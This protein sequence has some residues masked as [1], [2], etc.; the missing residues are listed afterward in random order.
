[1]LDWG[2]R[3]DLTV[4]VIFQRRF[5]A[6]QASV[7]AWI[8]GLKGSELE[9]AQKLWERYATQLVELA[10]RKLGQA[11]RGIADEEDIAQSV[12]QSVWRGAAAGRLENVK[13]RDDLW[14]LLLAITKQKVVDHIRRETSLKRGSGRVHSETATAVQTQAGQKF[15]LDQLVSELPTPEFIAILNEQ[16]FRLLGNLR[17]DQLRQI[18]IA[19]LEGYSVGEI[20]SQL[21]VSTR[22][23]ERKLHLIRAKWSR[24]FAGVV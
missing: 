12:F 2:E 18:A 6:L 22:S 16:N 13:S 21:A 4:L 5:S 14:W 10:R 8:A 20:A 23:I 1:M 19:R 15:S 7:S 11:P 9:A 3:S 17:D 24:D